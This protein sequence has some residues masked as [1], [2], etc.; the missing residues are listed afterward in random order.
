MQ[1]N[2]SVPTDTILPHVVYQDVGVAVAW[3][4]KTFGSIEHYRYGDPAGPISGAQMHLGNAWI[5]VIE[6]D[7][8]LLAPHNSAMGRR[9]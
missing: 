9:A 6:H 8:A 4:C 3:L 2:R 1:K 7:Q 5:M